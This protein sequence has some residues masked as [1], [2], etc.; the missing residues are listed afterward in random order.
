MDAY[1]GDRAH[2][3]K[4]NLKVKEGDQIRCSNTFAS[5]EFGCINE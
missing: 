3:T 4:A 5:D 2:E 1:P